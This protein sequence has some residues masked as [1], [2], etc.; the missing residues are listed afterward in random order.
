M[1]D[2]DGGTGGQEVHEVLLVTGTSEMSPNP[3]GPSRT[4]KGRAG[5]GSTVRVT[6]IAEVPVLLS[7]HT[8]APRPSTTPGPGTWMPSSGLLG[9]CT[10]VVHRHAGKPGSEK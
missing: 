1:V 9:H 5:D 3:V 2:F 6:A 8:S 7:T 4:G 10:H